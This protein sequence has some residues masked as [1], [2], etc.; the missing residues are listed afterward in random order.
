MQA[1]RP[2]LEG[3]SVSQRL[4]KTGRRPGAGLAQSRAQQEGCWLAQREAG[5]ATTASEWLGPFRGG[6]RPDAEAGLTCLL[7]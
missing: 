7:A 5:T 6:R 1:R 3:K 4:R 2:F